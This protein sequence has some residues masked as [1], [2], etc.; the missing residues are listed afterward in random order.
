M[1]SKGR[2]EGS[3]FALCLPLKR[4][5]SRI[6]R[7]RLGPGVPGSRRC[8]TYAHAVR[9]FIRSR[10]SRNTDN[11]GGLTFWTTGTVFHASSWTTRQTGGPHSDQSARITPGRARRCRQR[12]FPN[13]RGHPTTRERRSL[14]TRFGKLRSRPGYPSLR[15]A[16]PCG[17]LLHRLDVAGQALAAGKARTGAALDNPVLRT[18]G[19]VTTIDGVLAVVVLAGL[20]LNTALGWWWADPAAGYVL[21]YYGVREGHAAPAR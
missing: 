4:G 2:G 14:S 21:V 16:V 13:L 18:E 11:V 6:G 1:V 8:R 15:R 19:R 7:R 5:P 17:A 10:P 9:C 20:V 3:P 12:P